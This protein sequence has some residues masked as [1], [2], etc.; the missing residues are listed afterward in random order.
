MLRDL[1]E[2]YSPLY[3]LAALGAGGTAT[4]FFMSFMFI[5]PHPKTPIP[6][7]DSIAAAWQTGGTAMQIAI[8]V[9][10][11]GLVA[12]VLLHLVLL[13]WNLREFAGFRKTAAYAALRD[14]NAG[15]T[16]MAVPLTLAMTV[17]GMFVAGAT[18]VP[19]LWGVIEVLLPL[20]L[21]VF[22]SI[23]IAAL[24]IY[25]RFVARI[26]TGSFSLEANTG[27]NQLL[28]SFSFAMIGV[29][30][31]A[32]A[33]MSSNVATVTAGLISSI[34]F[35]VA[36]MLVFAVM[37]P[38]GV[39]S[40]LRNGLAPVNSATLWLPVPIFTL[41][42]ITMVRDNHGL[43]TLHAHA[44]GTE[45]AHGGSQPIMVL[46]MVAIAAQVL[47]LLFGH[48]LMRRNGYY[49]DYLLTAKH[50]S[51]VAFTL[52]CPGVALGVLGF[53]GLHAGL[54]QN[55]VVEKFG[56]VYFVI[57]AVLFAIQLVTI[58]G[59]LLLLK[60][61]I[62]RS[63]AVPAPATA[64]APSAAPAIESIDD[65]ADEGERELAGAGAR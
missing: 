21:A 48:T 27:L 59:A 52:V 58:A 30:L 3:F 7:F 13:A 51:P 35:M 53:F 47:F 25:G 63:A 29:G 42:G 40:M 18:L 31:A 11:T 1:G 43:Q 10:Y 45:V 39:K 60:N 62:F 26:F 46:L 16:L 57:L 12:F 19:G 56:P 15:V 14:S 41:W 64:A 44:T 32:G 4:L 28:G 20:A 22:G 36:S 17:N 24:V 9:A 55:G 34:F 2:K 38:L 8:A 5:T 33:A 37:L 54:V 65:A 49:V 50:Q 61:Q 23:G 6:T